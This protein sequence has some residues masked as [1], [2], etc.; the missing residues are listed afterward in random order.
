[1]SSSL[2]TYWFC[3]LVFV[4]K[5]NE[6]CILGF[7]ECLFFASKLCFQLGPI[8]FYTNHAEQLLFKYIFHY[9]IIISVSSGIDL[10][11]LYYYAHWKIETENFGLM[12]CFIPAVTGTWNRWIICVSEQVS[13]RVGSAARSACWE[14]NFDPLQMMYI[15]SVPLNWGIHF[16]GK[17]EALW[18]LIGKSVVGS[19]HWLENQ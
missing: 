3:D 17:T 11:L 13:H 1:V 14:V 19:S 15:G 5:W 9:L 6:I 8:F 10:E 12:K 18:P 7:C 2:H 16:R 4:Y